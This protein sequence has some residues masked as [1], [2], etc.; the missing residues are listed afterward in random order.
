MRKHLLRSVLDAEEDAFAVDVL[1]A[2]PALDGQVPDGQRIG[3]ANAGVVDH[4]VEAAVFADS[5]LDELLDLCGLR[6][7]GLH[8]YGAPAAGG[9][10]VVRGAIGF[11]VAVRVEGGGLEVGADQEGAF[12]CVVQA[13]C[14]TDA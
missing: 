12:G 10:E 9:D 2:V 14:A 6:D 4:D 13:D 8:E 11:G 1:H 5:G 7:V 3:D